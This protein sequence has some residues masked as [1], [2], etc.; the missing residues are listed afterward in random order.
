MLQRGKCRESFLLAHKE[1]C[2]NNINKRCWLCSFKPSEPP[3]VISDFLVLIRPSFS[4]TLCSLYLTDLKQTEAALNYNLAE[5]SKKIFYFS[6][7][8][9]QLFA[10]DSACVWNSCR[11][12]MH[13][14]P[15]RLPQPNQERSGRKRVLK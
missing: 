7:P 15:C 3:S 8:A 10:S 6:E 2:D 5:L 11:A 4:E 12:A 14:C 1:K 9:K 13:R